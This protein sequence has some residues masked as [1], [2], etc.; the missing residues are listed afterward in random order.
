MH[1]IAA[2]FALCFGL[3]PL[4]APALPRAAESFHDCRGDGGP[5][6]EAA[7]RTLESGLTQ[8][9]PA[10]IVRVGEGRVLNRTEVWLI[11][12]FRAER[13]GGVCDGAVGRS[14]YLPYPGHDPR[15]HPTHAHIEPRQVVSLVWDFRGC[16][17]YA[18]FTEVA[19]QDF[20]F[21][22]RTLRGVE[23]RDRSGLE[24]IR[25]RRAPWFRDLPIE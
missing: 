15:A 20:E 23:A 8:D 21:E 22:I 7:C 18:S 9:L 12:E 19:G 3:V 13:V 4:L 6:R 2:A 25:R 16:D 1:R 11:T 14:G 5:A 10:D 17:R 24:E